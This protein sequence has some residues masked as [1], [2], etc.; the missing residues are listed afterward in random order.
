MATRTFEAL[1]GYISFEGVRIDVE[2]EAPLG[3]TEQEKDHA[4]LASLAQK[5]ELNYLA[6]GEFTKEFSNA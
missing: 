5:V 1:Q 4:F 2:F 3:A 6:I